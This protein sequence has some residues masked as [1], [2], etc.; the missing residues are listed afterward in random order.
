MNVDIFNKLKLE[1]R[2]T[3]PKIPCSKVFLN[4]TTVLD[5][6]KT[7]KTDAF[8][9]DNLYKKLPLKKVD[10][11]LIVPSQ[12]NLSF[13]NLDLVKDVGI[14]TGAFLYKY[15]GKYYVLDG[16]HRIAINLMKGKKEIKAHV[17]PFA[18]N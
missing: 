6:S 11:S 14:D 3:F 10:V 5:R 12:K 18:K 9:V 15:Y 2:T 13:S 16:H 8:F 4:P 7:K 17:F 1:N